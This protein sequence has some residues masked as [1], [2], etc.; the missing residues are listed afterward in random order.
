ML[1]TI[2]SLFTHVHSLPPLLLIVLLLLVI[3]LILETVLLTL[4]AIGECFYIFY[5][6]WA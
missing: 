6:L 4:V 3:Y 2:L 5:P 1:D